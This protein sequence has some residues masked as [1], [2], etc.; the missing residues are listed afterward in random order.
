VKYKRKIILLFIGFF[1]FQIAFGQE[2]FIGQF[3]DWEE[4]TY[5]YDSSKNIFVQIDTTNRSPVNGWVRF[6]KKDRAFYRCYSNG[7]LNGYSVFYVKYKNKL[8]LQEI[9]RYENGEIRS[10]AYFHA[11]NQFSDSTSY[12]DGLQS[13]SI[14]FPDTSNSK[15]IYLERKNIKKEKIIGHFYYPESNNKSKYSIANSDYF[16]LMQ[17]KSQDLGQQ[18]FPYELNENKDLFSFVRYDGYYY[19]NE[20]FDTTCEKGRTLF[21][22]F[23]PNKTAVIVRKNELSTR[24]Y[25]WKETAN[26]VDFLNPNNIASNSF[27]LVDSSLKVIAKGKI[28]EIG[29]LLECRSYEQGPLLR[30]HLNF[31]KE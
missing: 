18:Y 22:K 25:S 5:S 27:A 12:S 10:R 15:L 6:V 26:K 14:W 2:P 4:T 13:Y 20:C 24:N 8:R 28:T 17:R 1:Y 16:D 19:F 23:L 7:L 9:S 3:V 11:R 30:Y 31:V 29:M 21:I